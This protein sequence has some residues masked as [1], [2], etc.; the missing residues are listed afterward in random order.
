MKKF[1]GA[2]SGIGDAIREARLAAGMS[3]TA[4][5]DAIGSTQSQIGKYE[6]GEQDLTVSRLL[7]IAEALGVEADD[8]VKGLRN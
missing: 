7:D 3:Q 5:A 2:E 8:L 1:Q 4:L 6:R